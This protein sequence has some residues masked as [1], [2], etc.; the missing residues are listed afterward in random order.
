MTSTATIRIIAGVNPAPTTNHHT[1]NVTRAMVMT[2]GTKT[3]AT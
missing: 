2:T 1:S 3:L